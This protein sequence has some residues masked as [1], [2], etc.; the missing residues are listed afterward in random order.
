[1]N[2]VGDYSVSWNFNKFLIGPDGK[3]KAYFGSNTK[4][5]DEEITSLLK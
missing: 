1:L 3:L 4:P 5:M 2:G